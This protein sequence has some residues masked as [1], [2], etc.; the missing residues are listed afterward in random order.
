MKKFTVEFDVEEENAEDALRQV[1]SAASIVTDDP[2]KNV[3]SYDHDEEKW[4]THMVI[5]PVGEEWTH[6]LFLTDEEFDV[7]TDALSEKGHGA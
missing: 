1:L 6:M 3:W 5:H 7:A 4:T 2:D